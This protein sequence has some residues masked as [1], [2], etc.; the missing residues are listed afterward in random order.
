MEQGLTK[1]SEDLR[2]QMEDVQNLKEFLKLTK[3]K[4]DSE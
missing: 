1:A 3:N 2:K 4:I